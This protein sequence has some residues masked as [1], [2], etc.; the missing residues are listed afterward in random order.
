MLTPRIIAKN[1]RFNPL[2]F[3]FLVIAVIGETD[4]FRSEDETQDQKNQRLYPISGIN[5]ENLLFEL[6][7]D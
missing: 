7:A 5:W 4:E 3:Q 6:V 1:F 2:L